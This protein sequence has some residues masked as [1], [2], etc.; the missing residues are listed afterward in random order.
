MIV[1]GNGGPGGVALASGGNVAIMMAGIA[2]EVAQAGGNLTM[3]MNMIANVE[4]W[5]QGPTVDPALE[6][7]M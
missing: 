6:A 7:C 3:N 2:K 4:N 5:N 1:P